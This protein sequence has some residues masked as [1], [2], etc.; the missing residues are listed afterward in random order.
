MLQIRR[1]WICVRFETGHEFSLCLMCPAF[2]VW[3]TVECVAQASSLGANQDV[4]L[5]IRLYQHSIN[6]HGALNLL[7]PPLH[8]VALSSI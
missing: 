7:L 8:G 1:L 2:A 4:K 6:I 5:T 3:Q